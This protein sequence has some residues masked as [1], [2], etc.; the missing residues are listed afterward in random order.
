MRKILVAAL[1][2]LT[3]LLLGAGVADAATAYTLWGCRNALTDLPAGYYC[4]RIA[5]PAGV[6]AQGNAL[7]TPRRSS[8]GGGDLG[9]DILRSMITGS[10]R[11]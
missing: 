1:F 7:Y 5:G 3:T 4:E 2:A 6:D 11:P 10:T 8:T 9:V